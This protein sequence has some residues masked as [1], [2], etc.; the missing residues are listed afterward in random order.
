MSEVAPA[1]AVTY[2]K[3]CDGLGTASG[4]SAAESNGSSVTAKSVTSLAKSIRPPVEPVPEHLTVRP[5]S[6]AISLCY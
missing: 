5:R 6:G 4:P 2:G 1:T 3:P